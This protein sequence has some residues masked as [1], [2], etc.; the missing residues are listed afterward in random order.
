MKYFFSLTLLFKNAYDSTFH[1]K[2]SLVYRFLY[3]DIVECSNYFLFILFP[4]KI[5]N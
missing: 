2:L 1:K 3:K 4:L 5:F